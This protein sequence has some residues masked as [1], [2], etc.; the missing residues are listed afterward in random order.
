M[1]TLYILFYPQVNLKRFHCVNLKQ[2]GDV[3]IRH[4]CAD[5]W[6]YP[7]I[8]AS[9]AR[10]QLKIET[11]D[12]TT[13]DILSIPLLFISFLDTCQ[14]DNLVALFQ[15]RM[16]AASGRLRLRP[17]RVDPRDQHGQR[18]HSPQLL[19]RRL[20]RR[21]RRRPEVLAAEARVPHA[22][23]LQQPFQESHRRVHQG[24]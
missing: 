2:Y 13:F 6:A 19:L 5:D 18:R 17:F 21:L 3:Y 11:V 22:D 12:L 4:E 23:R 20:Q 8:K 1:V 14:T 7:N 10:C 9:A 15:G 24:K 16:R